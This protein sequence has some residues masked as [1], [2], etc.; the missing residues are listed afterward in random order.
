[1]TAVGRVLCDKSPCDNHAPH[2][3]RLSYDGYDETG[4]PLF[5]EG[6]DDGGLTNELYSCFFRDLG[7]VN[8]FFFRNLGRERACAAAA[9]LGRR[10]P[11]ALR[12]RVCGRRHRFF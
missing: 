4:E 12:A 9:R 10:A 7:K 2:R 3:A 5:E 8:F 11:A 6:D 1:M